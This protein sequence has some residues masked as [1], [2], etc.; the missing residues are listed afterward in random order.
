MLRQEHAVAQKES[1]AS[2]FG[3]RVMSGQARDDIFTFG[4]S[5]VSSFTFGFVEPDFVDR[6]S[7][8]FDI[9]QRV[10]LFL[11]G[12]G[13]IRTAYFAG[14]RGLSALATTT[15]SEIAALTASGIR[16]LTKI[17]TNPTLLFDASQRAKHLISPSQRL[18]QA[19]SVAELATKVGKTNVAVD[20]TLIPLTP[21]IG[22]EFND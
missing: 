1:F 6:D 15:G 9:G 16:N 14:T 11:G 2:Y 19:G 22:S 17:T 12:S 13:A 10:S 4:G 21:F 18:I 7:S 20:R 5:L 8:A 3:E